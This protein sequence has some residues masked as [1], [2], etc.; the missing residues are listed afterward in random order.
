LANP[1]PPSGAFRSG[2]ARGLG[3][4]GS[5]GGKDAEAAQSLVDGAH[6]AGRAAVVLGRG[7]TPPPPPEGRG[8]QQE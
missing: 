7:G 2:A 6:V 5:G 4:T 1:P 3:G 8:C